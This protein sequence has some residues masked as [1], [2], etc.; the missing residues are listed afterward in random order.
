MMFRSVESMS[1]RE[2]IF[3]LNKSFILGFS[4]GSIGL[5]CFFLFA[6]QKEENLLIIGATAILPLLLALFINVL[7]RRIL[8]ELSRRLGV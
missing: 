7:Y 2:L 5:M 8:S 6:F 1:T 4:L 3:L